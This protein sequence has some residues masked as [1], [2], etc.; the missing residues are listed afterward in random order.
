MSTNEQLLNELWP[1]IFVLTI[2]DNLN[3][4]VRLITRST[5]AQKYYSVSLE[6][7]E[8]RIVTLGILQLPY[9]NY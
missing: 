6:Y 5:N 7:K 2:I 1:M 9:Q 3:N 8:E 4:I